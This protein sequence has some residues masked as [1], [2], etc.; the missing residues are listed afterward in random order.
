M[1]DFSPRKKSSNELKY[2]NEIHELKQKIRELQT[3]NDPN[4]DGTD[5]EILLKAISEERDE[6]KLKRKIAEDEVKRLRKE[7]ETLKEG[8]KYTDAK[9]FDTQ[10][11]AQEAVTKA[12][13]EM[14]KMKTEY[15]EKIKKV[16][17]EFSIV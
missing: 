17:V 7:L 4:S 11:K 2:L 1:D 10:V 15:E 8:Q 14:E 12:K 13:N 16:C 3:I 5:K 9:L 6:A